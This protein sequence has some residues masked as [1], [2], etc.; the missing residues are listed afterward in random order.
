MHSF[1]RKLAQG[2][3]PS[4]GLVLATMF[5]YNEALGAAQ[6]AATAFNMR[7]LAPAM[8]LVGNI[9]MLIGYG[10]VYNLDKKTVAQMERDLGKKHESAVNLNAALGE[11]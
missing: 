10:L 5:G 6:T 9:I 11:D 4:L 1:F 8:L 2:V 3:G 7:M